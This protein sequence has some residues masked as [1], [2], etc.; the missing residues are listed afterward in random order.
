MKDESWL[1]MPVADIVGADL[2]LV[3]GPL[4]EGRVDAASRL[5]ATWSSDG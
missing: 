3:N 4:V 1:S 2:P 5:K